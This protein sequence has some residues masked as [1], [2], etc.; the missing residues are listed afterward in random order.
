[1]LK[2]ALIVVLLGLCLGSYPA[3]VSR[4]QEA[5]KQTEAEVSPA[6]EETTRED[7]LESQS[8][9]HGRHARRLFK[10]A[11]W[12]AGLTGDMKDIY[13]TYG[14]PS[15]RYREEKV[16]VILEKW[17]YLEDGR[18]FIFRDDRL[19]RTRQFNPGSALG[20]YLK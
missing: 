16:G 14:Y 2:S 6:E 17:T 7:L 13:E 8:S 15:S 10:T 19:T 20:V 18:Q 4:A 3:G 1:M 5:S 11:Y 9:V 12:A